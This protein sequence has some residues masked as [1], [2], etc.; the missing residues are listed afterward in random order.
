MNAINERQQQLLYTEEN[1]NELIYNLNEQLSFT[2]TSATALK[3][4]Y[5]NSTG[6][7][8][9]NGH[10]LK[11]NSPYSPTALAATMSGQ[12]QTAKAAL[13]ASGN[14]CIGQETYE[15]LQQLIQNGNLIK[16]AVRRLQSSSS[17]PT[18]SPPT[19]TCSSS[20]TTTSSAAGVTSSV[21]NNS[22]ASENS[23][24]S[25]DTSFK[26]FSNPK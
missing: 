1:L 15:L 12:F 11:I 16:E 14:G 21:Y 18:A 5:S 10:H 22:T 7:S 26:Q 4:Q 3:Q 23:S 25:M 20:S 13:K 8:T 6:G 24:S 9:G 19:G 17:T 2:N